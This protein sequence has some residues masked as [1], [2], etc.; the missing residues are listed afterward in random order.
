[1]QNPHAVCPLHNCV[2]I[3]SMPAF[4]YTDNLNEETDKYQV[5]H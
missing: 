5:N 1:M 3:F 4:E 2:W